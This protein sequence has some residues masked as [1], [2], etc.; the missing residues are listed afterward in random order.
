MSWKINAL[1]STSSRCC[2]AP[3]Q[4]PLNDLQDNNFSHFLLVRLAFPLFSYSFVFNQNP[5]YHTENPPHIYTHNCRHSRDDFRYRNENNI[6]FASISAPLLCTFSC[7]TNF[8][9]LFSVLPAFVSPLPWDI[10]FSFLFPS[11][12]CCTYTQC[13]ASARTNGKHGPSQ[14]CLLFF[15]YFFHPLVFYPLITA[16]SSCPQPLRHDTG[17]STGKRMMKKRKM[18]LVS[19]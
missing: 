3:V 15:M 13:A 7:W 17:Q 18:S 1:C 19:R 10:A 4:L 8:L 11:F 2:C 12:G 16:P 6:K 5:I 9:R 14:V